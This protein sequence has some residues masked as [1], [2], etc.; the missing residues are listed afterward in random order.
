MLVVDIPRIPPEGLD[1]D[2]ELPPAALHLEAEDE[3]ALRPGSRVRCHVEIVDNTTVHVRG[4]VEGRLDV[5]CGRCLVPYTVDV[6][7]ELDQFYLPRLA[8]RP[9]EQEEE[10]ELGDHDVVV[11]YYEG[12]Q[13]DLGEVIREQLFLA[14][15]MK[16]LCREDCR[17]L[18]PTCGRNRNEGECGCPV[19]AEPIDQRLEPLRRLK[20]PD[21]R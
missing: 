19:A 15:P 21:R 7:Q 16:Q 5:E 18:C 20:D 8:S 3:F 9:E 10:V 13:L 6:A 11:G 12:E 17:G 4:R 2:A 14:L 1:L